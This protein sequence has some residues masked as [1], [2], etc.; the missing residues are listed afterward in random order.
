MAIIPKFFQSLPSGEEPLCMVNRHFHPFT[1]PTAT[2]PQTC[3]IKLA[4]SLQRVRLF[5]FFLHSVKVSAVIHR[6]IN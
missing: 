3:F 1:L 6:Y 2:I 5:Y 4:I